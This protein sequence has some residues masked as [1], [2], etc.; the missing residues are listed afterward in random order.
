MNI[1]LSIPLDE[2]PCNSSWPVQFFADVRADVRADANTHART[3]L[4]SV[5]RAL[6]G[7]RKEP[8]DVPAIFDWIQRYA[9]QA[10]AIVA[11]ADMLL[12]GGLLPSRIHT[13]DRYRLNDRLNTLLGLGSRYPHLKLYVSV[14]IMRSP[15][16]NSADEEPEYCEHWGASLHRLGA[17]RHRQATGIIRR[18]EEQELSALRTDIPPDILRDYLPRRQLNLSY[19]RQL[20]RAALDGR[21]GCLAI[22][23]DDNA[24]FSFSSLELMQLN[25]PPLHARILHYPGADETGCSLAARAW[26][27]VR[28]NGQPTRIFPIHSHRAGLEIIPR[29]ENLKLADCIQ[30]HFTL[31]NISESPTPEDLAIAF[32]LPLGATREASEQPAPAPAPRTHALSASASRPAPQ[33]IR[34]ADAI[35]ALPPSTAV[36]LADISYTNGGDRALLRLLDR[37]G[38]LGKLAFYAAWNTCGNTIGTVCAAAVLRLNSRDLLRQRIFEDFGYMTLVR[39]KLRLSDFPP[40]P[41]RTASETNA[42]SAEKTLRALGEQTRDRI[43]AALRT[44]LPDSHWLR[45]ANYTV[46]F[47]WGRP[48]EIELTAPN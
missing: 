42:A 14:V 23:Q 33:L 21:I 31:T 40:F 18:Q 25:I 47:P 36:Y 24:A 26:K 28:K 2:R 45:G 20:L 10:S 7:L 32:N 43:N 22:P 37:R 17:L 12:Y 46:S 5:P 19:T 30:K 4:R 48:F 44:E 3:E 6:L 27:D 1:I 13:L 39:R 11:S 35:A 29:Y 34:L 41:P 8:A 16:Y 15:S 38:L 9:G